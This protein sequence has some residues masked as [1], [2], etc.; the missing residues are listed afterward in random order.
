MGRLYAKKVLVTTDEA[1]SLLE[2]KEILLWQ[3]GYGM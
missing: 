2:L 1:M 3:D